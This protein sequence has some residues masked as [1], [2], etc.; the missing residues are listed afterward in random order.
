MCL[1]G[2]DSLKT[3]HAFMIYAAF[4]NLF[5][6]SYN[7]YPHKIIKIQFADFEWFYA[8]LCGN[9]CIKE[10]C[11]KTYYNNCY[12]VLKFLTWETGMCH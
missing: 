5:L 9:L 7:K 3:A 12:I 10:M 4:Y 1:P 11:C 2:I 6:L 8:K